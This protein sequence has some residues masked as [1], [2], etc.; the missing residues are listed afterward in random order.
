MKVAGVERRSKILKALID[1]KESITGSEFAKQ[2]NVSRQVV[3]GDVALL[4][5]S[6]HPI[7]ATSQG[8][9]YVTE[10]AEE[11]LLQRK[12]ACKH[13]REEAEEELNILVDHGVNVKDVIIE[14][15]VYGEFQAMLRI[16]N[17]MDV[18]HFIDRVRQS[19]A[20]LLSELT[21]GI[22]IHTI[23]AEKKV[24]LDEAENAMQKAG[25]LV[26]SEE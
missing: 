18:K 14:H 24:Y 20:S 3:V 25:F 23:T 9:L 21:G 11:Q 12:I 13:G 26:S 5:A 2:F 22:H 10:H 6:D 17:R 19:D 7:I 15:P 4:K 8:Y 1:S 16:S